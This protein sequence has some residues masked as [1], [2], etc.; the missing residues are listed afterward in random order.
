MRECIASKL[1]KKETLWL[2]GN[3]FRYMPESAVKKKK[4]QHK[5]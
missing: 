5:A 1:T 3:A 4:K 2:K